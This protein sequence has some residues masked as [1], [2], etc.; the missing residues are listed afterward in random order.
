MRGLCHDYVPQIHKGRRVTTDITWAGPTDFR[1]PLTDDELRYWRTLSAGQQPEWG[2]QWLV[3][4]VRDALAGMP[5]LVEF[6]EVDAL[7]AMLSEVAAGRLQI[8]QAGDCA[9]DPAHC[10]P[11]V[12]TRKVGMLDALAGAMQ[13]NSGKPV[14]RVGRI[15][16]QFAKPRSRPTE[17]HQGTELPA[18]RGHLVN[19]PAPHPVLRTPDPLRLLTCYEAAAATMTFLRRFNRTGGQ[20]W[21]SHEALVLDYELP[22]IRRDL[23]D[24]VVLTSTHLPWIGDRT[25]Q[26]AGAHVQLLATVS[27]PVAVKIGPNLGPAE[28]VQLCALLDPEREPGRLILIVRLGAE[29]VAQRLPGLVTAVHAAEHPV[30]WLCDPM[31][32]NTVTTGWGRKTRLLTTILAEVVEFQRALSEVGAIPGGLHLETSPEPITECVGD[33]SEMDR[34]SEIYTTLCDPRM[35][36]DQALTVARAWAR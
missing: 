1:L 16:G 18:F 26:V 3:G 17:W 12:L 32:A 23:D 9:E 27:N 5:G 30:I 33:E 11:D 25:R 13:V 7:R 28:L 8:V 24:R 31:H 19:D 14:L 34:V 20:V 6:A 2:D 36:A 10:V 35:N 22:L 4:Q 21:T 29:L 15:G